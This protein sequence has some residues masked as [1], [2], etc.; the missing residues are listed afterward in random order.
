M[1]EMRCA[2]SIRE[3]EEGEKEMIEG[4][5]ETNFVVENRKSGGT[6]KTR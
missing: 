2:H 1:R 4:C 6:V 3:V 5:V